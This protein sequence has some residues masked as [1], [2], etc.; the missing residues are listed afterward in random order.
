MACTNMAY[1]WQIEHE[2]ESYKNLLK[3]LSEYPIGTRAAVRRASVSI[4]LQLLQS[5]FRA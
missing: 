1:I 2:Y 4:R 3:L 5:V